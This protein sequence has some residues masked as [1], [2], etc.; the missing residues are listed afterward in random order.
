MKIENTEVLDHYDYG[1][2]EPECAEHSEFYMG[3]VLVYKQILPGPD[4]MSMPQ[5]LLPIS[6]FLGFFLAV[7]G[8]PLQ[9]P[10]HPLHHGLEWQ[11]DRCGYKQAD[12]AADY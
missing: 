12:Q 1:Q 10:P 9:L 7:P 8:T 2:H 5:G 11:E 4:F 3:A 6:G